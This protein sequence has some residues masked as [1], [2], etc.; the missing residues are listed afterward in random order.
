[1]KKR[2]IAIVFLLTVSALIF[3]LPASA[4]GVSV[5]FDNSPV[6]EITVPDGCLIIMPDDNP[7]DKKFD[8]YS[9]TGE[10]IVSAVK[11]AGYFTDVMHFD[12]KTGNADYDITVSAFS[13]GIELE[14][15]SVMREKRLEKKKESYREAL[16][17]S[18]IEKDCFIYEHGGFKYIVLEA[19]NS[20]ENSKIIKYVTVAGNKEITFAACAYDKDNRELCDS[21]RELIKDVVDSAKYSESIKDAEKIAVE[22]KQNSFKISMIICAAV[23][24]AVL[25]ILIVSVL[26][27]KKS[28]RK[29]KQSESIINAVRETK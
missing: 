1:M 22:K 13:S 10:K 25:V 8:E 5:C 19:D 18:L 15:F 20:Y 6:N 17:D 29:I 27:M 28:R 7:N 11:N 12:R 2:L 14:S 3:S 23:A 26:S 21:V 4:H 24:V 16:E 9:Q